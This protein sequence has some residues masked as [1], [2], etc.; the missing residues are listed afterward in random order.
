MRRLALVVMA[1]ALGGAGCSS[2]MPIDEYA[3]ELSDIAE[4]YVVESQDL[5]YDY[6]SSVEDGVRDIV[7]AGQDGAESDAIELVRSE[8]VQ[9]LAMLSDAMGRYLE[10]LDALNPP[11]EVADQHEAY[12]AA[13]RN[14][15]ES[16]PDARD[17]VAGATSLEGVQLALTAS[18]FADGQLR[19]TTTCLSL[20]EAVEAQGEPVTLRCVRSTPEQ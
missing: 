4:A 15:Y 3:S 11:D 6:Q 5:S 20:E 8:T 16:I 19:W 14:V 17:T 13:V 2:P 12:V 1:G 10:Q 18:G 7:E 9:Y